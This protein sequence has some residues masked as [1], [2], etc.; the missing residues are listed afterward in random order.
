MK[1][2]K[3]KL[4]PQE[5]SKYNSPWN[6]AVDFPIDMSFHVEQIAEM[7]NEYEED[8]HT[9]MNVKEI[10][11][12][13]YDYTAGYPYLVSRICQL[14]DERV[15]GTE[16]YP[17]KKEAWKKEG[18]LAAIKL[19]LKEPNTLFD[20]MTKKLSDYPQLKEMLQNILFGGIDF[21][22]KRETPVVDLGVTF[23]FLK[24]KDGIVAVANRIFEMQLYDMFLA[25][26]A[27]NNKMYMETVSNRSQ[28]I[29]SGMLQMD[30]VMKKFFEYYEEIYSEN[31]QK[32]AEESSL[33]SSL[34]SGVVMS[35]R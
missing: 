31:D 28:F 23:G 26:M 9:G 3:L 21:P 19:L 6:I 12:L 14:V 20:D 11:E 8:Y 16:A 7:V 22:F 5:E 34:K 15:A 2:L 27:V 24:D 1:T 13:L 17:N 33:L 4:H 10:A 29:I 35:T 30:L 25:E 18:V 32:F